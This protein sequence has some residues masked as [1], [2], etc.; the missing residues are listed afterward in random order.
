M[1]HDGEDSPA[2][3]VQA[4]D[5]DQHE[6]EHYKRCAALPGAVGPRVRNSGNSDEQ[7]SGEED[8]P[9]LGKPKPAPEP[10]PIASDCR[11]A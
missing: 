7:C 1:A 9:G 6:C 10:S 11:H 2:D 3:G 5:A 8:S 4:D